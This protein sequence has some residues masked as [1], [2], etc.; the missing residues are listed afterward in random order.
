MGINLGT[1]AISK[2][3]L[4][5]TEIQKAYL[6]GSL[7]YDAAPAGNLL[8]DNYTG[9]AAAWS[10]TQIKTGATNYVRV[11]R[12]SDNLEADFTYTEASDGT[13]L[14]FVGA[15]DGYVTT[16]YDGTGGTN[17]A[18][19]TTVLLQPKIVEAGVLVTKNGKVGIKFIRANSTRLVVPSSTNLLNEL[20][21]ATAQI[22]YVGEIVQSGTSLAVIADNT[23]L[24]SAFSSGVWF[25]T[26]GAA[27]EQGISRR[28]SPYAAYQNSGAY[29]S[30]NQY[31]K[32]IEFDAKNPTIADRLKAYLNAG[33]AIATNT[34]NGVNATDGNATANFTIGTL[35]NG[36]LGWDG[37]IQEIIPFT[38]TDQ[39]ANRTAIIT[40]RNNYY[41]VY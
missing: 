3:Y 5:A 11:R 7:V 2:L 13:L 38:Q 26:R 22:L 31:V 16:W 19:Q 28:T 39:T 32:W 25:G 33:S 24:A 10:S 20:H 6:G 23:S 9:A 17:H 41:G 36:V 27:L 29:T 14:A 4:G 21:D 40:D 1:G 35:G 30:G 18:V 37:I 34:N 15:N 8:L 12:S